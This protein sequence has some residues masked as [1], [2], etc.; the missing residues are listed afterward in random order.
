[1]SKAIIYYFSGTKN[2][3]TIANMIKSQFEEKGIKTKLH[4][5]KKPFGV[6]PTPDDYDYVGFGYPVHAFNSPQ[7]FLQFVRMLPKTAEKKAFIFKTAGEPFKINDSSSYKLFR[8]LHKKGFDIMLEK[9]LLM[10]YNVV[11][12]YKDS[13]V[14]QMYLYNEALCQLIIKNLVTGKRESI[15]Y[16]FRHKLA[17]LIFR[18]QWAGAILNGRIYTVNRKKCISCNLCVNSCPTKNITLKNGRFKFDSCCAMCMR[19]VMFCPANA[20]NP[21]ILRLWKVNGAY[22]FNKILEDNDIPYNFINSETKGYFRLFKRYYKKADAELIKNGI[23]VENEYVQ[24]S[25]THSDMRA[26]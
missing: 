22:S 13:L 14:K 4:E 10:P 12:R 16:H 3:F 7:I 11:F 15:K 18:V 17:S 26:K 9:H 20:I 23:T 21:G 25:N 1:M 24:N 2:T 5:I 19:C 8:L 6:F